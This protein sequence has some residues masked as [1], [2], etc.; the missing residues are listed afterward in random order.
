MNPSLPLIDG[1]YQLVKVAGEGGMATVYRAVQKGAAGFQRTVAIKHI[2]PEFRA[3]KNYIDMFIEE[4][5]VGSELQH[6]NIVQVHDFV[7]QDNS[8]YLVMEWVEGIDLGAFIKLHR[9]AGQVVPWALAAAIGIGTLRG[10]S[11]AHTRVAPDGTPAPIIHRDVSPHNV[12]L[13]INGVVKLSDFG[14]ARARDRVASLT[15][16]G[17]VKGKLSY[18]APEVTFGKANTAQSDLFCVGSVLWETLS[19]E[20]LF[21]GKTD[22]EIFKKIRLC[23]VPS[24]S[25]RRPDVP[26]AFA[27]VLEM[28]TAADPAN[29]YATADEFA[30]ALSQVMKQA[31]G[32]NPAVSL[33]QAVAVA[34]GNLTGEATDDQETQASDALPVGSNAATIPQR[35]KRES[36]D[37]EFSNADVNVE[38]IPLTKAKRPT[39]D[40]TAMTE[41]AIKPK[42]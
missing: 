5:R 19:G 22:V 16:P 17:T 31:V 21:D 7:S 30:L 38:P 41:P 34:R 33:G 39:T 42:K 27:A 6:P 10:L 18:L 13:G 32:V 11:A 8:Y 29:R 40:P 2:K 24:I 26:P 23:K 4:A 20:R 14:L 12:L 3:I 36:V 35:P 15:A 25:E 9:D 28:A 37:V 1:K